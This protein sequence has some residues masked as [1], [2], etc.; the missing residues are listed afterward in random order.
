MNPFENA[1]NLLERAAKKANINNFEVLKHP[2]RIINVR[3]PLRRDDGK[4]VF[5]E[6]YRVQYNDA[7]G[8]TKGGIRF[9][10]KVDLNEVKALAFWMTIKNAV[11]DLPY[12]GAKGGVAINPKELSERELEQVSR[13]FIKEIH[14]FVGPNKD[15]PAP[16]V[17]TNDQ[18]MAWM[19]DEFEKINA[20]SYP[21]MITGKPLDIG[22]S[23]GRAYST[24][25]GGVFV[26]EEA[27]KE[28]NVG[29][30]VA[31]QGFGNAG[32]NMAKFLHDKGFK[33][34]AVSDSKGGIYNKNGL[35]I[36][37]VIEI[38]QKTGSVVN[39]SDA[40][41]ITNEEVL[42]LETDILIPAALENQITKENADKIKAKIIAELANGPVSFEADEILSK[43]GTIIIPDVLFNAGGV[44]VSYFEWVQNLYGYYWSEDE[45]NQRL[46]EKMTTAFNELLKIHDKYNCNLRDAAYILAMQ[47]VL[48][49]EKKRGYI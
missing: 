40:K 27:L 39:Y 30:R 9:H 45:V 29:K 16:D 35:D 12:G 2:K 44:T 26:L 4:V 11:V 49:A 6:G 8:P 34:I 22:G 5:F 14:P 33:I 17:Y 21:G 25:L 3:V 7:R 37:K 41:K 28:F 46:K 23:K 42:E 18:I 19:L 15:I 24:A 13:N 48:E 38:K 31:I 36:E 47:R 1:I 20:G 43:K 10:P 32:A